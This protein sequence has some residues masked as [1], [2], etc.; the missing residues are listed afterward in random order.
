MKT[1]RGSC[2]CGA[3]K[4]SFEGV[5]DDAYFCHCIQCRKNYGMHGAFVGVARDKL[6]VS[7]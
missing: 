5:L 6:T 3:V 2:L 1:Q 7:K 4:F